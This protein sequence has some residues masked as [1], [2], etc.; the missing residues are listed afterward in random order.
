MKRS[1]ILWSECSLL[2]LGLTVPCH[3]VGPISS[4]GG[5]QKSYL[6]AIDRETYADDALRGRLEQ[7]SQNVLRLFGFKQLVATVE[8]LDPAAPGKGMPRI[9]ELIREYYREHD[10]AGAMLLGK[11][12]YMIWRQAAGITWVNIGPEDFCFADLEGQFL[13]QETRHGTV[14]SD[15]AW[16]KSHGNPLDNQ[17]VPGREY[18]PDGQYETHL[19]GREEGP[20]IWV[21]RLY[22][23]TAAMYQAYFDK[24]NAYYADI[25]RQ[26]DA[27][28]NAVVVPFTNVLYTRHPDFPPVAGSRIYQFLKGFNDTLPGSTFVVLGE[29]VGG[30]VPELFSNYNGRTHFF[31]EVDGHASPYIHELRGGSYAVEDVLTRIDPGRGGLIMG[32]SGCHGGNF[33]GLREG[34]VNLTMAYPLSRGITQTAYGCSW[35]G[36]IEEAERDI[37]SN[38]KAGDYLGQAF[39]KT[40]KRLYSREYMKKLFANEINH[41]PHYFLPE[42]GSSEERMAVLMTKLLRGHNLMGNPFLKISY[43]KKPDALR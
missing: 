35:S 2:V 19:S 11:I 28:K 31:A 7:Y 14:S 40:Q 9:R 22:A 15:L 12:P 39:M 41:R 37:L 34:K 30:T 3:G 26:L 27:D 36:G 38:L 17:L 25:V 16:T 33:S 21:S 5:A 29:N 8:P 20:Q 23:P 6:V 1:H 18:I 32:L 24:V 42:N 4:G 13:D 43:T 10:I